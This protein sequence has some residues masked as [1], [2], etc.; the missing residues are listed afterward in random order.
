VPVF[1]V[2][3]PRDPRLT[4][5][6][7]LTD[8]DLRRAL[9]PARGLY[10]AEGSKV[11]ERALAA[12]HEPRSVLVEAKRLDAAL[13]H[14]GRHPAVPVY[15]ASPEVMRAIAGYRVHR[16]FLAAMHRPPARSVDEVCGAAT[17]LLILEDLVDHTNV[18]AAFRAAAALG[19]DAVLVSPRCADPFYRR[20]VKVSMG[21]IL[22]LPWAVAEH[23]PADLHRLRRDGFAVLALTPAPGARDLADVAR[24]APA[25]IALV[26][27][28]EGGGLSPE[29][30]GAATARVRIPMHGGIDSLNAA[31]AAAVAC[32]ALRP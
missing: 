18:G 15:A 12:G 5:Y 27:G 20:S 2:S 6:A 23:W 28:T 26:I 25:R 13:A 9:E 22:A 16:G 1:Q 32:Y 30:L 7:A 14:L 19:F 11:I 8:V 24:D 17:R 10:M 29:V 31:A 21:A 3:D 4:D